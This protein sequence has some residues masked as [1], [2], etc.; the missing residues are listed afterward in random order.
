MLKDIV[1]YYLDEYLIYLRK[2]RSDNA[3]ETVEEVLSRH[4]KQLQEYAQKELGFEIKEENIYREVVS[5]ETIDDRPELLKMLDRIEKGN[6]KGVLVI[7][8]QRLSRGN[9]LDCG[10][11]IQF[12]QYTNTL[13]MT[14]MKSYN[15]E[16]KYDRK[17]FEMELLR[18]NDYLEY[19]KEILYRGRLASVKEGKFVGS[20]PP[21]G[22]D[23]EKLK[24]EKGYKL[25]RKD[26]E[27]EI[28]EMI[29]DMASEYVG[30]TN[31][32]NQL[33][34]L[35]VKPKRIEFW[36][37]HTI[38]VILTNPVYYGAITW[39]KRKTIQHLKDGKI[40]KSRPHNDDFILVKGIHE[41]II[42]KERFDAVQEILK[43][44][45][46]PRV[47][48][49]KE[50][51]NPLS[52]LVFCEE[53][54]H[55]MIRRAYPK[56]L[57]KKLRRVYEIEKENLSKLLRE[58]KTS[59]NL[60][61]VKIAEE[62]NVSP[63]IVKCWFN[64]NVEKAVYA[65]I[66][67]D[68]WYQ[69]KELLNITTDEFDESITTYET[70]KP[71]KENLVCS[72]SHCTNVSSNLDIVEKTILTHLERFFEE[73]K[74]FILNYEEEVLKTTRNNEKTLYKVSKSIE[75]LK[76]ELK[77]ARRNYNRED[78]TKEEYLEIKQEIEEELEELEQVK[79]E[80]E[81]DEQEDK[82][83]R[84]KKAVPILANCIK[85]YPVLSIS[86][87]NELLKS[88]IEKV[89]YKKTQGGRWNPNANDSIDLKV[90]LKI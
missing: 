23:K 27:A 57:G 56:S 15:I 46:T 79:K 67:S 6:I 16:D 45:S 88:I 82:I 9:L 44:N 5:G 70:P 69:I 39:D 2:S 68:N 85:K 71:P 33:N 48:K 50:I 10:R 47:V 8:P 17:F 63:H 38:R 43:A 64:P 32:A 18:G 80:I 25:V 14:P 83:N 22:Y 58:H 87:K 72:I 51:K 61:I 55:S 24:K 37:P 54:G 3:H 49:D 52:G 66:F 12:F 28:V 65:K 74:Y 7:E 20:T 53:C 86:E 29:F 84:Y 21:F 73:Y 76:K 19:T 41:P 36:T 90:Y 75:Q 89:I 26:S 81:E 59:S 40:V 11:I 42:S 13:V 31:I 34:M 60:S 62:L 35:K 77:T 4:E 78:Y 1:Q 30:T